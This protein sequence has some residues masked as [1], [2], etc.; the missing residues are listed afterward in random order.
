MKTTLLKIAAAALVVAPFGVA[1]VAHAATYA[2][3]NQAMEV[4]TVVADNWMTAIAT[5]PNIDAHSG[6]LLLTSQFANIVGT[7]I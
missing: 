3:V 2:Y 7:S 5:A 1:T 6:V 4:R